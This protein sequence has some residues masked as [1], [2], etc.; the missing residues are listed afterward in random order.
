MFWR[1]KQN[2]DY[3]YIMTYASQRCE[4]YMQLEDDIVAA[5]SYA[6]SDPLSFW[7]PQPMTLRHGRDSGLVIVFNG[8]M[9]NTVS[10]DEGKSIRQRSERFRDGTSASR[11]Q[12]HSQLVRQC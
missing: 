1:T 6:D 12:S 3:I 10:S 8:G 7:D 2:I 11:W 9:T 5:A 4:Y